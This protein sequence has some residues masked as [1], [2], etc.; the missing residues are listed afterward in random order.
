[1]VLKYFDFFWQ[2]GTK[3][4]FSSRAGMASNVETGIFFFTFLFI[5]LFI[6]FDNAVSWF[7]HSVRHRTSSTE[8]APPKLIKSN[9]MAIIH[10]QLGPKYTAMFCLCYFCVKYR[11]CHNATNS[12]MILLL[13]Q[14][15]PLHVFER[16]EFV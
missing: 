11:T 7:Q 2:K 10:T 15:C 5:Y 6:Y 8:A 14:G 4:L 3:L 13:V 9:S 16:T 1:M 12:Q